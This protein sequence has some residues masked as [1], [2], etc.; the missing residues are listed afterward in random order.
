MSN[1]LHVCVLYIH[2]KRRRK[3]RHGER[4]KPEYRLE[5]KG[6]NAKE[7]S[8]VVDEEFGQE[9]QDAGV[10][11]VTIDNDRKAHSKMVQDAWAKFGIKVWPGAG[12][13][14]DRKLISEF[15]GEDE[16]KLGG[17]QENPGI[18]LRIPPSKAGKSWVP[19][20]AT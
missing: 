5:L 8:Y 13:V 2:A 16:E 3:K 14:S 20:R 18:S 1:V 4:I 6:V 7:L 11:T 19:Q 12:Y 9:L 17:F 10:T 15:T